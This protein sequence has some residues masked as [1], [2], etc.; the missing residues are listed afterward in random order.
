MKASPL[1]GIAPEHARL[2]V[3]GA[4]GAAIVSAAITLWAVASGILG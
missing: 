1:S 3:Y 4:I 2:M